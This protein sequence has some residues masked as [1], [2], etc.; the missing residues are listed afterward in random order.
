MLIDHL[1]SC[2]NLVIAVFDGV[3]GWMDEAIG[4]VLFVIIF[5]FLAKRGLKSLHKHYERTNKIWK[6]SFVQALYRPLSAYVWFFALFHTLDLIS[7]R[8]FEGTFLA[9]MHL[10][11]LIGLVLTFAW[12]LMRWKKLIVINIHANKQPNSLDPGK[13]DVID[14][15]ATMFILFLCALFILEVTGR[16]INTLIAFGGVGGLAIAFASQEMISNFFGGFMIYVTHPFGVGDW[17]NLPEHNVEG[18][19]EEIG[20]YMTRIRTFEKRPIYIP[21]SMFSKVVVMTPSRMSHRKFD[22][23][24]GIRYKDMP[25]ARAIINDI[26]TMLQVHTIVDRRLHILVHLVRFGSYS[27][28]IHI[29]AYLLDISFEGYGEAKQDLLFKI[30]DIL[31]QHGA[32]MPIPI[33]RQISLT[34]EYNNQRD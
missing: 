14:K 18:H 31:G 30:Y 3:Y 29:I 2:C 17:I 22:E 9:N 5:N 23:T 1:N 28:D 21:N 32:E 26:K 24:I 27:V 13:I 4:I 19:V 16:N 12:F 8:V 7:H 33:S 20:W 6:D 10:V 11:L 25:V 34:E 15:L